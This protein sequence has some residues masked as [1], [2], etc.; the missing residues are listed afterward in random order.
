MVKHC[1]I[2]GLSKSDEPG[3]SYHIFPKGSGRNDWIN[4]VVLHGISVHDITATSALCS[5]HFDGAM[6]FRPTS[7]RKCLS[8]HAIPTIGPDVETVILRLEDAAYVPHSIASPSSA[9]QDVGIINEIVESEVHPM[10]PQ[11]EACGMVESANAA[12]VNNLT[13]CLTLTR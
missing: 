11:D 3:I 4:F 9:R 1:V 13:L 10:M 8:A 12:Q 5:R 2:C 7:K 6:D